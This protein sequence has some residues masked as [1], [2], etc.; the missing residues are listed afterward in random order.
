V[1]R[2]VETD[3]TGLKGLASA[4]AK[5]GVCA[6]LVSST[7]PP[8]VVVAMPS[9][10]KI[11]AHDL[12]RGLTGR[13]GGRGGGKPDLAQGGGFDASPEAILAEARRVLLGAPSAHP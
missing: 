3:A 2:T 9:G 7:T 6:V 4:L 10:A 8:L 11:A 13:F 12:L 1:L 5:A